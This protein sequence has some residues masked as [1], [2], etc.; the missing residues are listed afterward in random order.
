MDVI[1]ARRAL[2]VQQS[3]TAAGLVAALNE[4]SLPMAPHE[5]RRVV[6]LIDAQIRHGLAEYPPHHLRGDLLGR[7]RRLCGTVAV[8]GTS[9]CAV[10]L[11]C[12]CCA[13]AVLLLCCCCAVA[14]LLLCCCCAVAVLLLCYVCDVLIL[15]SLLYS[16]HSS[17]PS[18]PPPPPLRLPLP[19][20]GTIGAGKSTAITV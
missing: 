18:S 3:K 17:P 2:S 20:S 8:D 14:V 12:C 10:L 4:Y 13:V 1:A 19:A 15:T 9:C 5:A 6:R 16:H 7:G 11:L